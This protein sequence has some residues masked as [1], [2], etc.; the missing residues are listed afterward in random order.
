MQLALRCMR[1]GCCQEQ[2]QLRLWP[3]VG[4]WLKQ[5]ERESWSDLG[6]LL[7]VADGL[8]GWHLGVSC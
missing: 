2:N 5:R 1:G 6:D 7:L 3:C 4:Y 8:V